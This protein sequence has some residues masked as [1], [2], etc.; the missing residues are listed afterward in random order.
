MPVDLSILIQHMPAWLMVLFRLSGIFI[1]APVLGSNMIPTRV[2][3]FLVIAL[4][5][6]VYPMLLQTPRPAAAYLGSFSVQQMSLWSL[7]GQ[8]GVE[9]IL[10][11]AI[12]YAASLPLVAMQ[13]GGHVIDQQMG[14]GLAGIYNPELEEQSGILGEVF[15]MFAMAI[16]VIVGGHRMMLA[17]LI[18][19]FDQIPLGGF[20]GIGSLVDL[21][22]GLL[23]VM[24][25]LSVRIAA[26]ITALLF[27]V[28][29]AM[30][31]IARTVPQFNILSVGFSVRILV[32]ALVLVGSI[33]IIGQVY[34]EVLQQILRQIM[35]FFAL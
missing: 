14:L 12:G 9:L 8:I 7:G 16:F 6:C 25:E 17:T 29:V 19:S 5:L 30:G 13:I 11:L 26:P 23:Q 21:M 20:D 18:G 31:F 15:F 27:L 22:I 4:S 3:V 2:K 28:T 33:T 10:G 34:I 32:T 35:G 24:F 1:F